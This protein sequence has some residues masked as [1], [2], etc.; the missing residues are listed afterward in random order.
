[1]RDVDSNYSVVFGVSVC[2]RAL[3][4]VFMCVCV[5]VCMCVVCVCGVCV[6]C[7]FVR[8]FMCA[9]LLLLLL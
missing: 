4:C 6:V 7:V 1:M 9:G 5:C 2:T 3:M 8:V